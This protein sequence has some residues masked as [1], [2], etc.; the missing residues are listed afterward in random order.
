[1]DCQEGKEDA[2][3]CPEDVYSFIR[4][5]PAQLDVVYDCFTAYYK[6]EEVFPTAFYLLGSSPVARTLEEVKQRA[7]FCCIARVVCESAIQC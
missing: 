4:R 7:W 2:N 6:V 3:V 5:W 1:M